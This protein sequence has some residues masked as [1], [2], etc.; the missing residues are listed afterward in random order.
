MMIEQT[1]EKL[2]ALRLSAMV[3]AYR[4]QTDFNL[5][6]DGRL[7]KLVLPPEVDHAVNVFTRAPRAT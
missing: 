6:Q 3:D 7:S 5:V 2:R 4:Q 1:L